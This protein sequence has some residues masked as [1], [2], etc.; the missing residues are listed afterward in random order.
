MF[1]LKLGGSVITDKNK[2]CS[3][4]KQVMNNL[5]KNIKNANK[6]II[7]IHG[8]GSFGHIQAKKFRLNEGYKKHEQLHGFS[9][10]H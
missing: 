7:L 6:Q 10:T 2:E 5:A 1:I 4:K 3:F 8:A 9:V